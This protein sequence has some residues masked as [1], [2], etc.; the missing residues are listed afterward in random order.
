MSTEAKT[1]KQVMPS[2]FMGCEYDNTYSRRYADKKVVSEHQAHLQRWP[3][4]Q[5][6]VHFWVTLE[7]GQAVGWNE[8]PS[9]G[10]SFP[11]FTLPKKD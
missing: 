8:S 11:T 2:E 4:A 5:K 7:N 3:G 10:W 9:H 6:N 1:L